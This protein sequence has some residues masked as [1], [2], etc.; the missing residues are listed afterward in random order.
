MKRTLIII[1][2]PRYL[3]FVRHNKLDMRWEG[4]QVAWKQLN[5]SILTGES[6]ARYSGTIKLASPTPIPM[7]KR[8]GPRKSQN[9]AEYGQTKG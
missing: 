7:I 9:P 2:R 1:I 6:S 5:F 4:I 3:A 8:L